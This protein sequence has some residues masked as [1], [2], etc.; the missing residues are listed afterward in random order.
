MTG[1]YDPELNL[2]YWGTGNP[3]PDYNGSDRKGDNL[4][5]LTGGARSGYWFDEVVFY[6]F[7]PH[8]IHDWDANQGAGARRPD[9]RRP[10]EK[11]RDV[12]QQEQVL[13]VLDRVTG[14]LLLGSRLASRRGAGDW[15]RRAAYCA[16]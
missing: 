12:R 16:Q 11:G 7:T 8:D 2:I 4:Y 3:A 6:Q 13:H 1:S 15:R 10:A 14:A 9:D 5:V